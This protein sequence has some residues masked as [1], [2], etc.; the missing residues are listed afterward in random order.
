[1]AAEGQSLPLGLLHTSIFEME[2][3]EVVEK[4]FGLIKQNYASNLAGEDEKSIRITLPDVLCTV[5]LSEEKNCYLLTVS[6][7]YLPEERLSPGQEDFEFYQ[8]QTRPILDML[9]KSPLL[10][11]TILAVASGG[12]DEA[13]NLV[14]R[15]STYTGDNRVSVGVVKGCLLATLGMTASQAE[16]TSLKMFV[17]PVVPGGRAALDGLLADIKLLAINLARLKRLYWLC[18]PYFPQVD[19]AEAEV[20][21]RIETILNRM[22]QTEPV[23]L[24]TLKKWLSDVMNRF[25]TLSI[26]SALIKRDQITARTYIEENKNLFQLWGES[27]VNGYPMLTLTE[28]VGYQAMLQPFQDFVDRTQALRLQLE[29]VQDMVR[30]YLGIRHQ[31]QNSEI[32]KQQVGMLHSIEGHEKILKGLTWWVVFLTVGLVTLEILRILHVLP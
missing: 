15:Y 22:R 8:R 27:G 9:P 23:E 12:Q 30:T 31:E 26:L 24:E 1:M 10:Q 18:Q 32:L 11:L 6:A 7:H 14:R 25:S 28:N 2:D 4:A 17:S 19:P 20:Q 21:E 5:E 3:R 16:S 13:L 29:T